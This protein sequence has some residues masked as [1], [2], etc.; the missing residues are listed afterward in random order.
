MRTIMILLLLGCSGLF[1]ACQEITV[2][3]LFTDVA[4]YTPDTLAIINVKKEQAR[5]QGILDEFKESTA[6]LQKQLA[7]LEKQLDPLRDQLDVLTAEY[8][9]LY[10]ELEDY[11]NPPTPERVE[12]IY[13]KMD[14]LDVLSDE[15][16]YEVDLIRGEQDEINV[17]L[18]EIAEGLGM[19]APAVME[20]KISDYQDRIDFKLPWTSTPIQGV[21]GTEPLLYSIVGVKSANSE[22]AAKFMTYVGVMGGGRI[23][24]S[25]DVDVPVGAYT[26]TL[27]IK[28]E[29]RTKVL[30]DIFTFL[31]MDEIEEEENV[32]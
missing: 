12:E 1:F 19:E 21:Q 20:K 9:V 10:A 11:D 6:D 24:V 16:W 3:C 18:E 2:G 7:E 28:N 5:L 29:G 26:I 13:A 4:G 30:E 25:Q 31:V 32:E 14:E 15:L 17:E 22:N 8:D 27:E 23:Y